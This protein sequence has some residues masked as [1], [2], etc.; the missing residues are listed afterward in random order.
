MNTTKKVKVTKKQK[1]AFARRFSFDDWM[2]VCCDG[3]VEDAIN[4]GE[5]D[6]AEVLAHKVLNPEMYPAA[7]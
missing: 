1:I 7:A 3:K 2:K 6:L 4:S 5:F